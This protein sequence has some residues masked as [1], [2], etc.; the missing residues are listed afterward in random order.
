MKREEILQKAEEII[1]GEREHQY[2]KPENNF[3]YIAN[4]WNVY[5]K[6]THITSKDVA[7]MLILLKIAR[8]DG[9]EKY[10]DNY[11]DICG[12]AACAGEVV[13]NE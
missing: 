13:T 7:I 5:L 8:T 1:T 10:I 6:G 3:S 12:Y 2:G 4:L 9:N 11:I